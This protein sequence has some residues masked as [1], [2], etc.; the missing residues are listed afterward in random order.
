[1]ADK[2][3][4][5]LPPDPNPNPVKF[6]LP[7]GSCDTHFHLYG[8]PHRFPFVDGRRYPP[9]AAPLEHY[10]RLA[11]RLGL[12]RGVL[13]HPAVH[14]MDNWATL[15]ALRRSEGRLRGMVRA[16]TALSD[17]DLRQLHEAGVRGVR[18]ALVEDGGAPFDSKAFDTVVNRVAKLGWPVCLHVDGHQI[19]ELADHLRKAPVNIVFDH[20][21][22]VDARKGVEGA[23][24]RALVDLMGEKN[25]WCKISG[26]DRLM[27][28][29]A[30]WEDAAPL[31]KALVARAGDRVVWGLDWPHS[32][33]FE[34][35]RMANDGDLV[36]ALLELVP[37][38]TARRKV[39]VD[40]PAVLFDF[41]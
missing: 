30:R 28:R 7:P 33:V 41:K 14:G 12:Q 29:G 36:N 26:I 9:P 11:E 32:N 4:V 39:L 35:G 37:D 19:A 18:F 13:V 8:P 6:K 16:S 3:R 23:E 15:D 21:G 5:I 1:M 24:F 27:Q 31:S 40:N 10:W 38:E 34:L 2:E 25:M 17:F 20:F 22:R